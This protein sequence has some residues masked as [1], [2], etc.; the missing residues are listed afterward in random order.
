[1]SCHC[2]KC[3]K[4]CNPCRP[5]CP[6]P[7]NPCPQPFNP[8]PQPF[9]PFPPPFNP[10]PPPFSSPQPFPSPQPFNSSSQSI[11]SSLQPFGTFQSQCCN[12][13]GRN[14][15]HN[16]CH[17]DCRNDC[18]NDCHDDHHHKRHKNKDHKHHKHEC[19]DEDDGCRKK[20]KRCNKCFRH[21]CS[22][23]EFFPCLRVKCGCITASLVKSASPNFYTAVGQVITY[24]Y[25]ITNTGTAP[26]CYPIRICDDKLGGQIIPRAFIQPGASQSFIRTYTITSSD[27]AVQGIT[28]TASAYI[29]VKCRK[30]VYTQPSSTTITFGSADLRG[31]ISQAIN[32]T[33]GGVTVTVNIINDSS[34]LTNA[35]NA[36][37]VLNFPPNIVP[38]TVTALSFTSPDTI[39]VGAS[40]VTLTSPT[41]AI[42]ATHVF[43]FGYTPG[44]Y[45][46]SG[47]ITSSTFDPNINNNFVTSTINVP[48]TIT[49][50]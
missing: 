18:Q 37:L 28:N 25:T 30:W 6:Q 40:S 21:N 38:G 13:C 4:N 7:F 50:P 23:V 20:N 16:D 36:V 31:S 17:N 41:V 46:W 9:N 15:C 35:Q 45:T 34:S 10:F 27:L 29:E 1:M 43:Q 44:A 24:T 32:A 19:N 48:S 5:V 2:N 14:D 8:C 49:V 26:I 33:G 11:N 39:N 12:N 47:T 22:C 3:V 42:G